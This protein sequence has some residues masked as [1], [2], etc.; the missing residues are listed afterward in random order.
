MGKLAAESLA[1]G[2]R[3]ARWSAFVSEIFFPLDASLAVPERFK[4]TVENWELGQVSLSRFDSE[5]VAYAREKHHLRGL[6]RDNVLITFATTAD[7][8]FS[9]GH[10]DLHCPK[11][12]FFI[13]RGDL[14]YQFSHADPNELWVLK[15]PTAMLRTRVRSLDRYVSHAHD[16]GRGVGALFLDTARA[17]PGRLEELSA[18]STREGFGRCLLDLLCLALEDD[19]RALGS[20]MSSVRIGHLARLESYIRRNLANHSMTVEEIAAANGISTRYLHQLFKAS[21]TTAG[22][23]IRQLRLEAARDDLQNPRRGETIAEIAYRWGFGDQAQFSRHF[24]AHF[25]KTPR[26][27]RLEHQLATAGSESLTSRNAASDD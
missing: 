15:V 2:E 22:H 13:Q 23:W 18:S 1:P 21:N 27:V 8:R 26:E 3:S 5:P 25:D 16:A 12:G 19:E 14:P 4:G 17:I 10:C 9:Q 6:E 11:N 24:K 7:A 20:G